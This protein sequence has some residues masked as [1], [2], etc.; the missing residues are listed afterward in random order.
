MLAGRGESAAIL[1]ESFG[2]T[3][4]K[5]WIENDRLYLT[6]DD[7]SKIY[8]VDSGQSCCEHRYME[9]QDDLTKYSGEVFTDALLR[10]GPTVTG[11]W[12]DELECQFLEIRTD[13]DSFSVSNY[14]SHNGYYGGF[15]I[16]VHKG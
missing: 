6:F 11:E 5:A 8:F 10:D 9:C 3:I 15:W 12:G 16:T 7:D 2:K 13:K 4:K 1:H 14:N